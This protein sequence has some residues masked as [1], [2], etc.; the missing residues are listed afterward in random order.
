MNIEELDALLAS[1]KLP[2]TTVPL[3]LRGDL[4]AEHETLERQLTDLR[5]RNS[6][7]LAGGSD[8]TGL[9]QRLTALEEQM[10][11]STI[12]LRLRALQRRP[13]RELVESHPPRKGDEGDK[14]LG[15]NQSTFLDALIGGCVVEPEMD[16][17]RLTTLLDKLSDAQFDKLAAAAWSLNRR[18]VG[19]PFSRTASL[20]TQSSGGTSRQQSDSASPSNASPG[21]SRKKSPSTSTKKAG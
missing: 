21:G 14:V 20:I 12:T 2:E 19:V 1:A 9:A 8:E 6:R 13:W 7:K 3:C 4:Q 10:E 18:D 16:A 11:S 15:I 5:A 17:E